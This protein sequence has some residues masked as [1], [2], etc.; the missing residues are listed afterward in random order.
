[1]PAAGGQVRNRHGGEGAAG[2]QVGKQLRL[3]RRVG[4]NGDPAAGAH[5]LRDHEGGRQAGSAQPQVARQEVRL[6][7]VLAAEFRGQEPLEDSVLG[8]QVQLG[9]GPRAVLLQGWGLPGEFVAQFREQL[10]VGRSDLL[11]IR[12]DGHNVELT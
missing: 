10:A 1:V 5:A 12:H 9:L 3:E 4:G 7:P 6:A 11:G 8:A 2:D